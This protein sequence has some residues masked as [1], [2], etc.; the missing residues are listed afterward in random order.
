LLIGIVLVCAAILLP[1]IVGQ[2]ALPSWYPFTG[3]INLGLDLQ[4]GSHVVYDIDLDKA[5]DD[6]AAEIKR[7]LDAQ[8]ASDG[9]PATVS[10]P[11]APAGA[12]TVHLQD[13]SRRDALQA[14]VAAEY[15][16]MIETRACPADDGP[17]AICFQVSGRYAETVRRSALAQAVKTIRDRIDAKGVAEPTVVEKGDQII[18]ELPGLDA[19]L[20]AETRA[21]IARTAKL[22]FKIVDDGSPWM[23]ALYRHA[24]ADPAAQAEGI[25]ADTDVWQHEESGNDFSDYFLIARDREEPITIAEARRSGCYRRGMPERAGR[26][27][28]NVTGRRVIERYLAAAAAAD[29]SMRVPAD[30]QIG[31]ELV[32]PP[33]ESSEGPYWRTY[34]LDRTVRLT[35][36]AISK[37]DVVFDPSTLRPEVSVE[38][39]RYGTWRFGELT[40]QNVGRKMAIILDDKVASAPVI[41]AA[42]TGGRSSITMGAT[43]PETLEREA[44]DLVDVLRTGSL[45]APL[46]EESVSQVGPTLGRDA[47]DRAVGAFL[48]GVVVVIG[49]VIFVYRASGA[50][51]LVTLSLNVVFVLTL[52]AV[53][54]A[55]LTLPGIAG[56]VLAFGMSVDGNIIIFERIREELARG[57]TITGAVDTGFTRAFS[58]I[59]DGQLTTMAGGFVL[60][61]YGTGPITGFAVTL[62]M[63]NVTALFANI[64]CTRVLYDL[65]VAHLTKRARPLSI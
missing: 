12:V 45:P 64:W 57:K 25:T 37:A 47:V 27:R 6:R 61:Q 62:I 42:I 18:V 55:T 2:S 10:T 14:S 38:F 31:F 54:E 23:M 34:Y 56:I 8:F 48:L 36:S 30:A 24:V 9:T 7:D 16:E 46:R 58:A 41:Q 50:I 53:F 26:V 17:Q 21:L 11:A 1:M 28:C 44:S 63:G 15:G 13:A 29:P 60:L 20:I 5:L 43:D 49:I 51:A 33:A 4:G 35:G 32:H 40:S 59:V 65:Y 52:M 3:Q 19:E 22:E 39:N